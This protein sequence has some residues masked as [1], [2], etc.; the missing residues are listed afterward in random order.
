MTRDVLVQML[1]RLQHYRE[2]IDP[3]RV[4]PRVR[5]NPESVRPG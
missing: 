2:K 4:M 1:E 3:L 5:W